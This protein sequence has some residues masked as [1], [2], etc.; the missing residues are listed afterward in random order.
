MSYVRFMREKA[1]NWKCW[2]R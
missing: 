2:G 1:L